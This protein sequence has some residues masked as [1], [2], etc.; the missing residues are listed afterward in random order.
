[1]KR[2]SFTPKGLAS[3][4]GVLASAFAATLLILGTAGAAAAQD[5]AV[6]GQVTS[7]TGETLQGVQ[8]FIPGTSFGTLTDEAGRYRMTGVPAGQHNQTPT[9]TTTTTAAATHAA[10]MRVLLRMTVLDSIIGR[11][12]PR[13]SRFT[14]VGGAPTSPSTISRVRVA[15]SSVRP[16]RSIRLAPGRRRH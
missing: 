1:M 10:S 12:G 2:K 14:P 8:I 9:A 3:R 7:V 6:A 13:A 5:G 16:P 15:S 11:S 4:T